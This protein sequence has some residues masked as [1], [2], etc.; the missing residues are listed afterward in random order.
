MAGD[1]GSAITHYLRAAA[2]T[3]SLAEHDYL[4]AKAARL[5]RQ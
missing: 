4:T 1:T 5:R 2:R 3:T